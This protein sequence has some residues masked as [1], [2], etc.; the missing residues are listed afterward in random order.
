MDYIAGLLFL[1]ASE[2]VASE[3]SSSSLTTFLPGFHPRLP[4][5]PDT[6]YIPT[7]STFILAYPLMPHPIP[8]FE[9][10]SH[11]RVP[12]GLVVGARFGR[13]QAAVRARART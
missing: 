8:P 9:A 5:L 13:T 12:G 6:L 2:S 4:S 3:R 10:A 11:P 1:S 7:L